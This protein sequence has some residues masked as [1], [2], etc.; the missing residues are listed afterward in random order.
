MKS[1]IVI[2]GGAVGLS[3]AYHLGCRGA[4]NVVLLERHRL[5]SGTSWHAAGI[6]GPLRATP[7]MTQLAMYAHECFTTLESKTGLS[8]GYKRTGGYWLARKTER[9][10]ELARIASIGNHYGLNCNLKSV[11]QLT[12]ELTFLDVDHH[13]GAIS[14]VEDG[15]V[16]PVDLCMAYAKAA[17]DSGVQIRENCE[18]ADIVTENGRVSGVRLIDGTCIEADTVALCAGAW[19]KQLAARAGL[20]LPLQAVEHMY[21]VT[22]PVVST[23]D[24]SIPDP[25]PVIRDLD[26]GIY[27]K[28]DSGGKLVIGGFEPDAKCWDAHSVAGNQPFIELA[29]DW[30]QFE[31]FMRAAL[32]LMPQLSETGIQRFL[33]GP[34]SFTADTKPLVGLA[35]SVDGLF[36]AAGMNSTGIMSSAGIGRVLANWMIDGH[37]PSDLWE[38]DIA[39]CDSATAS[40]AHMQ[41]RMSEA[42]SD[43][44]AMHW[45]YKQQSAGRF[46]HKSVLHDRWQSMGAVFGVTGSLERGLWFAQNQDEKTLPYSVA[47][48][49]WQHVAER[50]AAVLR[51]GTALLDLSAFA[52]FDV[53]G[54]SA[55]RFL[56]QICAANADVVSG[57]TVY[58]TI[59]NPRGGIEA[60]VTITRLDDTAFRVTSGGNTRFRDLALLQRSAR[61]FSGNNG[62]KSSGAVKIDDVTSQEVVLGVMGEAALE[63]MM[64]V[65]TD[66]WIDFPFAT[67]RPVTVAAVECFATRLSYIG[68]YGWELNVPCAHAEAVF[69]AIVNAGAQPLGQHAL[70]SCRIEKRFLHWGH[71]IGPEIT[72]L[73]AGLSR[74]IDWNKEFTGKEA[75]LKQRGSGLTKRLCLFH[76]QGE[77][78]LLHDEPIYTNDKVTGL[79]TSGTHGVR[80]NLP[81]AIG[82][83]DT[84]PDQTIQDIRTL[85]FDIEVAGQRYPATVLPRPA[86]DPDNN[87]TRR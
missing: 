15:N 72:P 61:A 46:L 16:N 21:V 27:I 87:Y 74:T 62:S 5:T 40:D 58:S 64:S 9:M 20:S 79:T 22:E 71:D 24:K 78:L 36:V 7:G 10:D 30:T 85:S 76:V 81:L 44:F 52:K 45:P 59:L 11:Q 77:P 35:P 14:V 17:R 66:N 80:T 39:R 4:D 8:T 6:V 65:S 83:V 55:L 41:Q 29:E 34:E 12:G 75:L 43:L 57:R 54:E 19:S 31:P 53:H 32:A 70:N 3:V 56:Q 73:E 50:E 26:S 84:M 42:V 48:Q 86:F 69:D 28:G 49:N 13:A 47:R 25:F 37:A 1:I 82:L 60:D 63:T 51:H 38:V 2:G 67:A 33:N 23:V 18:V 68:E